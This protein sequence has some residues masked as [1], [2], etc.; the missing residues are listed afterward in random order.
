MGATLAHLNLRAEGS[1]ERSNAVERR[2]HI[3]LFAYCHG[4]IPAYGLSTCSAR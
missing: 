2:D 3:R 4:Q 1:L